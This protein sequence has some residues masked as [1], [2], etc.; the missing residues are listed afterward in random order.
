MLATTSAVES[1]DGWTA[2]AA[3]WRCVISVELLDLVVHRLQ[4]LI[5][6]FASSHTFL[7]RDWLVRYP[8]QRR[9]ACITRERPYRFFSQREPQRTQATI[10]RQVH[11][12]PV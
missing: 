4:T 7:H 12:I 9:L 8:R 3:D 11:A 5:P 1:S 2:R 10:H 6:P